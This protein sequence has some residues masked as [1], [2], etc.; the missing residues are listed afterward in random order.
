MA[1]IAGTETLDAPLD[2]P[3]EDGEDRTNLIINYLPQAM[4]DNE[5]YSMFITVGQIVSA[6]IM[7]DKSSG[8]SYGYGFVHY[9]NPQDAA[10]AIA[11]LNGLQVSN[12][13]IKVSYS[14]PN[15]ADIKDTNLYVGNVP[16]GITEDDLQDLFGTYGSI[17]TK[18]LLRDQGGKVKGIAFIRFSKKAEADAAMANLHGYQLP[19]ASRGLD[20]KVAE[21][22]GRQKAAFYAGW[23]VGQGGGEERGSDWGDGY[24][25]SGYDNYGGFGQGFGRGGRGG[26]GGGFGQG[27]GFGLQ[28]FAAPGGGMRGGMGGNRFNP[29]SRGGGRGGANQGFG[30]NAGN[31]KGGAFGGSTGFTRGGFGGARGM[32]ARGGGGFMRGGSRGGHFGGGFSGADGGFGGNGWS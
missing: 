17:L 5:L 8:Y 30:G 26:S 27:G 11:T 4:T 6:K 16:Q 12:K 9:Q 22:H 3:R 18:K 15:T 24:E 7:R 25:D 19:G 23:M 10:K 14:R 20:V 31:L 13:R 29:M 1:V 28:Q 21:D 2:H 32:P